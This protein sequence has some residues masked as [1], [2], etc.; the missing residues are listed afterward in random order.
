MRKTKAATY[1]IIAV[2]TRIKGSSEMMILV[3]R[4]LKP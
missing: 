2:L 4:E 1:Q 3:P